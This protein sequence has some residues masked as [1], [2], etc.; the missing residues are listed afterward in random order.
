MYGLTCDHKYC[1]NCVTEY[2]EYNINN[3]QVR[4]IKCANVACPLEY[5]RDEIR[6]FGS[7]EIY[8][9]YLKFKENIDVNLNPDLKWCPRPNCN[10]YV[11][12]GKKKKVTCE[13]GYEI[14]FDCGH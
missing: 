9:K 2:L 10:H 5:T 1:V 8:D 11:K 3:G 14:C 13:C 6:L 4:T 7:Q 12:K